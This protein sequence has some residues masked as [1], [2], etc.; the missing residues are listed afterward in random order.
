MLW[1]IWCPV[2]IPQPSTC[3]S[4]YRTSN[5]IF[6]WFYHVL[7]GRKTIKLGVHSVELICSIE[8]IKFGLINY[9]KIQDWNPDIASQSTKKYR[10]LRELILPCFRNY[11]TIRSN[12]KILDYWTTWDWI[13]LSN[14]WSWLH[15]W[16]FW[17]SNYW[18]TGSKQRNITELHEIESSSVTKATE[19]KTTTELVH[20]LYSVTQHGLN[21][22][23]ITEPYRARYWSR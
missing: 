2:V 6:S 17:V 18:T 21:R 3:A 14:F 8:W 19:T 12:N 7:L 22:L 10:W 16:S 9:W 13:E 20:F 23:I 1:C 11:W 5:W 15:I 4:P